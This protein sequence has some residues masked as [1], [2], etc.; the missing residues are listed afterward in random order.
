[1][2][3][4]KLIKQAKVDQIEVFI[5]EDE[6]SMAEADAK[7][8]TEM[9][10]GLGEEKEEINIVFAPAASHYAVYEILFTFADV[11]WHKV[12]AFH[13]DEYI[14]LPDDAPER[15]VNFAYK[16][17]FSKAS[18]NNIFTMRSNVTDVEAECQRY[19]NLLEQY[20]LDIAVIG[21]GQNGHL[22]YNEP[23]VSDFND[24][25]KVKKINL[26]QKSINQASEKDGIF[27]CEDFVPKV[28][29]TMT[30]PAIVS[31]KHIFLAVPQKHKKDA[32]KETL[33]GDVINTNP[34]SI[35]RRHRSVKLFL[36]KD[37]SKEILNEI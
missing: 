3:Q 12:N 17:I 35:L 21:I 32:V 24:P 14:G 9:I 20:P 16:H 11:P 37:S 2:L 29:M 19:A 30:V 26:D 7:A 15:I 4:E 25:Y 8:I 5:Y 10:K 33:L 1:M 28:A 34:A 27:K 36:D 31:A 6:K 13:L 18:F 22:A 23:H